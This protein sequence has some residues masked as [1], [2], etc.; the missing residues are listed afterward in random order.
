VLFV[1]EVEHIEF[2][3]SLDIVVVGTELDLGFGFVVVAAAAAVSGAMMDD[4]AADSASGVAAGSGIGR[5]HE[6]KL[7][8]TASRGWSIITC[9]PLAITIL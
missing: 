6:M 7:G 9:K 5:G 3:E 4:A 1:L 8:I 2:V